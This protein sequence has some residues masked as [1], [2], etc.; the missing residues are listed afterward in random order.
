MSEHAT[1]L[2]NLSVNGERLWQSLMEMAR[3]G[4]T[5][6]GGVCRL[7]LTDLDRQARELFVRW[8]EEAGCAVRVDAMGN[9][10]AR[11]EGED[12]SLAPV[13]TGSHL[14]TQPTGGRFDGIYGVM[15]GL[16]IV[17]TLNDHDIRTRAPV[18]VVVWTNEEGSRFPPAMLGSGVFCGEF[19][20]EYG[21]SR[22]DH[23]GVTVGEALQ[24]IGYLGDAPVGSP[25]TAFFETHIEQGPIL[26]AA[27][28]TI[29]VVTGVQGIRWYDVG[30]TGAECH[31]GPTPMDR[32][33]DA[34][35]A[36]ALPGSRNTVPGRV[37]LTVDLRHPDAEAL[38][39]M[40]RDLAAACAA[41]AAE[42]GLELTCEQVWYSPPVAFDPG[43]V[44]AVRAG[45]E[46]L[47]YSHQDAVSGAGHDAVYVSRVAPTAMVFIPCEDGISHN[48]VENI[49]PEHAT[50]GAHVLLHAML[51]RAGA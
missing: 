45:A 25:F 7:A 27:G 12:P 5:E 10:F 4:A 28:R 41:L 35:A 13:G 26:E 38:E 32:R 44:E 40:G 46:A 9:V 48:E 39:S 33:R 37:E 42:R 3:I 47:G 19:D 30:L 24:R 8:C 17:R 15:A 23:D 43:C 49:V 29:G 50:A 21:H 20:L 1:R 51:E 18:E 16:E 14:D 34:L 11:R 6:K 2:R 31:A 22:A 36:A